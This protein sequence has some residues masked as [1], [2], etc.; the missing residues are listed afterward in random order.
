MLQYLLNLAAERSTALA[1]ARARAHTL[2]AAARQA[3]DRRRA[4]S[5]E[6]SDLKQQL[7]A[8]VDR[9]S[10]L[11]HRCDMLERA[12]S[13]DRTQLLQQLC[14]LENKVRPRVTARALGLKASAKYDESARKI[15]VSSRRCVVLNVPRDLPTKE[16]MNLLREELVPELARKI[17][18]DIRTAVAENRT[19]QE[20]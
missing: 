19:G 17:W 9:S 13:G 16:A 1:E 6:R 2:D 5:N 14:S 3:E 12:L 20:P 7:E 4:V 15:A 18:T 8:E 10:W 11:R